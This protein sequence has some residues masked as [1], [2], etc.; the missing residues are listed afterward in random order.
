MNK[1][2]KSLDITILTKDNLWNFLGGIVKE[3][4]IAN[5]IKPES[6]DKNWDKEE[7]EACLQFVVGALRSGQCGRYMVNRLYQSWNKIDGALR[8]INEKSNKHDQSLYSRMH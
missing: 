8:V 5:Q 7:I 6:I 4:S 1:W 3:S 2:K